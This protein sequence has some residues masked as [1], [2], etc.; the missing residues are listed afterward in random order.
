M[1]IRYPTQPIYALN[2][3]YPNF[4][5]VHFKPNEIIVSKVDI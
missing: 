2:S 1:A 4:V 5:V 3:I